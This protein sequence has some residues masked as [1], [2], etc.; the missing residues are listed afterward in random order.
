[1]RHLTIQSKSLILR[2]LLIRRVIVFLAFCEYLNSLIQETGPEEN[3]TDFSYD[4]V[5]NRANTTV[6]AANRLLED[7][8][9]L[10]TYDANGNLSTKTKKATGEITRYTYDFENRLI[11]LLTPNSQL[12]TYTY[13]PFGRRIEK[14]VNGTIKSYL[15]D[16]ED[17]IAEYDGSGVLTT[18]YTHGLG[19][20]E[21]L[22]IEQKNQMYYYHADG[23]GSIVALT[24]DKGRVVQTYEYDSFGNMKQHGH[25]VKQ[26][27]TFTGREYDSE[28]GLY[29]YRARYYDPKIGRF[30]SEDPI[31]FMGGINK[32]A[33]VGNNPV[34]WVDPLGLEI[35]L[36]GRQPFIFRYPGVNRPTPTQRFTP[37]RSLPKETPAK[38][39]KPVQQPTPSPVPEPSWWA[40]FLNK[41]ADLLD[42]MGLGGG[43]SPTQTYPYDP[44]NPYAGLES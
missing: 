22:A 16:N 41:V 26:P 30:I 10:Y 20:D 21:P 27:Y 24:D 5:G 37:P 2:Y 12:I 34:N 15:Y 17:I 25:K 13:D 31:G 39:C 1:M 18:K 14:N 35:L 11:Q 3:T 44:L 19:I 7:A 8:V 33:Y 32:Y 43:V 36:L 40:K 23:L 28:T 4:P 9:Y 42:E 38:Q 6:D 29:Y